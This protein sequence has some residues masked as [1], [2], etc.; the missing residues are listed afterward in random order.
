VPQD[1]P[2]S[3]TGSAPPRSRAARVGNLLLTGLIVLLG[4]NLL[5]TW[6]SCERIGPAATGDPA[7]A[8]ALDAM[9]RSRVRL[10][11]RRGRVVALA[12][13]A[14]WCAPCV[15][16]LPALERLADRYRDRGLDVF[17][18]DVAETRK[19]VDGLL[20][21]RPVRLPILLDA[22]GAV[23]ARYGVESLPTL[24][25][26]DRDGIVRAREVGAASERWLARRFDAV[27]AR[28]APA[29]PP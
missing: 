1:T 16:E 28:P 8:F 7:P 12:F 24:V 5:W 29:T 11:D 6:R 2:A 22:D 20:R 9:D 4:F 23:S 27:L 25:V 21:A 18:V 19:D 3:P 26:V 14:T 13:F 17:L 10:R 15:T